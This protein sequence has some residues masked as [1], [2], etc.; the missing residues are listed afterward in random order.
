MSL[1]DSLQRMEAEYTFYLRKQTGARMMIAVDNVY[2][3]IVMGLRLAITAPSEEKSQE[4]ANLVETLIAS[5][6]EKGELTLE[7]IERAKLEV[8]TSLGT[9][10]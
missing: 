8:E 2:D 9:H 6:I 10:D 5:A 7:D 4:A 3:A 1:I